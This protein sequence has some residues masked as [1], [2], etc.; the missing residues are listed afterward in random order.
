[1]VF[2]R[3]GRSPSVL[4]ASVAL[5]LA[6]CTVE[7]VDNTVCGEGTVRAGNMCVA[8]DVSTGGTADDV[9]TAPT[10]AGTSD[11]GAPDTGSTD[12]G[13]TDTTTPDTA[14]QPDVPAADVIDPLVPP[15]SLPFAV[16]GWYVPSGF[17]G[18][19]ET[20]GNVTVVD[21]A[22]DG[23]RA[24]EANG[25]CRQFTWV[26]GSLPWA[27]VFWQY[28]DGNWGTQPGLA[29]PSGATEVTFWAWGA[30]G[31]EEVKFISGIGD[32]DGFAAET[33]FLT[34]TTTATEYSLPL[35]S[36]TI[37]AEVAGAFGWVIETGENVSFFVD[38]IQWR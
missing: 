11:T 38:D 21:N 7:E 28:P 37:G 9:G 33:S 26:Q 32:V 8:S 10:D 6:G 36:V 23:A 1:M 29:V 19:A 17:M 25:V 34:L 13:S 27:G 14:V 35:S 31:G 2:N 22:C 30:S 20:F 5:C 4:F 24:G 18:D 12:T 16:D 15:T 3:I